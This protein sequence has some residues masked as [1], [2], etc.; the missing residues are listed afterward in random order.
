[1]NDFKI[2][3][4]GEVLIKDLDKYTKEELM[5]MEKFIHAYRVHKFKRKLYQYEGDR[6]YHCKYHNGEEISIGV[7]CTNP[8]KEWRHN[9]S[10]YHHHSVKACKMFE[11]K[12]EC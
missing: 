12:E 3:I 2:N 11:R 4:T 9:C 7:E 6:C 8:N 5:L 1:M 10:K